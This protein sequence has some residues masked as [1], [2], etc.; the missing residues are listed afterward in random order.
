MPH[1]IPVERP[2]GLAR[3]QVVLLALMLLGVPVA[4]AI[5][6]AEF[7]SVDLTLPTATGTLHHLHS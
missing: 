5:E 7:V 2:H 3:T 1:H 6:P 4:R